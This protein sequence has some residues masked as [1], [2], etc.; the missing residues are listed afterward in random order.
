VRRVRLSGAANAGQV[1]GFSPEGVVAQREVFAGAIRKS[2][3]CLAFCFGHIVS[4]RLFGFFWL[5]LTPNERPRGQG[6]VSCQKG[7]RYKTLT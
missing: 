1:P 6:E 5:D 4:V 2:M 3:I 7:I